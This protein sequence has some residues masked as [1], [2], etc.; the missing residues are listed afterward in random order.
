[1]SLTLDAI[2]LPSDLIWVDEYDYSPV[3]Q[4]VATAVD[5]TLIVEVAA[6]QKGRII[7]LQGGA[8]YAWIDKA[9]LDS[10]RAKYIQPGL[11]MTLTLRGVSYSVIFAQP[12]GL[13]AALVVDYSNPDSTDF[14]TLTL[15][16]I[17]V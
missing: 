14:Y 2:T 16:F 8:D 1:M 10:I 12:D 6:Q 3:R 5:G 15:K 11:V 7:T 13:K 4:T 17:E 9:T